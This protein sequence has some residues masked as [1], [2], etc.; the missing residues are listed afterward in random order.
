MV[1]PAPPWAVEAY[2]LVKG[3]GV[4]KA[5]T[6]LL[7]FFHAT[8]TMVKAGDNLAQNELRAAAIGLESSRTV[9][10]LDCPSPQSSLRLD[11]G[12]YSSRSPTRD[13]MQLFISQ[14]NGRK[15]VCMWCQKLHGLNLKIG[16]KTLLPF[17]TK[18]HPHNSIY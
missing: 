12:F 10:D 16:A 3:R 9:W 5:F 8:I 15:D 2:P 14:D 17:L 4:G 11:L 18:S 6:L 1:D 7:G 13:W